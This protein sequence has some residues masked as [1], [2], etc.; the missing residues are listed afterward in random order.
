M[1]LSQCSYSFG[2]L[3]S[4]WHVKNL[5]SKAF[6]CSVCI[7]LNML[8]GFRMDVTIVTI[9]FMTVQGETKNW[10]RVIILQ[11]WNNIIFIVVNK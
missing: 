10:R 7:L 1:T 8:D 5:V 2:F 11:T 4:K 9:D 6:L 3:S